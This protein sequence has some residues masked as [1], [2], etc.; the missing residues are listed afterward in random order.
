MSKSRLILILAS[1]MLVA[2][3][4][5]HSSGRFPLQVLNQL[6][7]TAYDYRLR[8]TMPGGVDPRIVIKD[9]DEVS[10]G[11]R[12]AVPSFAFREID[13][14]RVKG[15]NEPV[16]I[17]EPIGPHDSLSDEQKG[18]LAEL[19]KAFTLYRRQSWEESQDIFQTLNSLDPRMIYDI[20]LER[21]EHFR[22]NP[23]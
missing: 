6:E 18:Q 3:T 1:I 12:D 4:V 2:I 7:K 23:P 13:Q 11:T 14:V 17:F 9:L 20:Y 5:W 22:E 19:E 15:K 16:T 21:I 8:L 10:Q